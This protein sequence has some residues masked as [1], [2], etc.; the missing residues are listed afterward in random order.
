MVDYVCIRY[1]MGCAEN[2]RKYKSGATVRDRIL[3]R[4]TVT[5]GPCCDYLNIILS[6]TQ[7]SPHWDSW[8]NARDE[9]ELMSC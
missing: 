3:I 5:Q 9:N 2:S 6:T 8:S 1:K 7:I 4:K